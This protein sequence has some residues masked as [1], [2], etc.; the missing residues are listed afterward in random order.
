[1]ASMVTRS[2]DPLPSRRMISRR[3]GFKSLTRS[4]TPSM[5]RMPDPYRSS[6]ISRCVPVSARSSE[7]TSRVVRTTGSREGGLGADDALEKRHLAGGH[8]AI[9]KEQRT[10]RLVLRS[11]GTSRSAARYVRNAQRIGVERRRVAVA[12]KADVAFAPVDVCLLRAEGVV[13]QADDGANLI[14]QPRARW[15]HAGETLGRPK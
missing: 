8:L 4:R 7:T 14:E 12:M 11:G 5:M 10:L 9:K 6:A 3:S 2:F 15:I 1:M 13:L